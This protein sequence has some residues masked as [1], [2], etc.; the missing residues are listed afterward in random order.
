MDCQVVVEEGRINFPD[1]EAIWRKIDLQKQ[2]LSTFHPGYKAGDIILVQDRDT[3]RSGPTHVI[4]T[5]AFPMASN[6]RSPNQP[7]PGVRWSGGGG[8]PAAP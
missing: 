1:L 7:T 2:W 3:T 8:W 4:G 5:V 6:P